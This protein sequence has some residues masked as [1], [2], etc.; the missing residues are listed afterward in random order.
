[1]SSEPVDP[2]LPAKRLAE[3]PVP[4][5]PG[6]RTGFDRTGWPHTFAATLRRFASIR[7]SISSFACR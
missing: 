5:T 7:T 3:A 1:M 4:G 2:A 6:R